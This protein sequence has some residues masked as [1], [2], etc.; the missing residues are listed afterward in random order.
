MSTDDPHTLYI[1]LSPL[2]VIASLRAA[3]LLRR[4]PLLAR[5]WRSFV[6]VLLCEDVSLLTFVGK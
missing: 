3:L 6:V 4:V 2:A 1:V 5:G